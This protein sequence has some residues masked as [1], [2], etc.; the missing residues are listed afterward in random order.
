MTITGFEMKL[1]FLLLMN[2]TVTLFAAQDPIE[3]WME[4]YA[5][6]GNIINHRKSEIDPLVALTLYEKIVNEVPPVEIEPEVELLRAQLLYYGGKET[7]AFSI[8]DAGMQKYKT[9][10]PDWLALKLQAAI[11]NEEIN[12]YLQYTIEL[13][14]ILPIS[15][16][17]RQMDTYLSAHPKNSIPPE[18]GIYCYESLRANKIVKI[19]EKCKQNYLYTDQINLLLIS[20]YAYSPWQR[21]PKSAWE[22]IAITERKLGHDKLAIIAFLRATQASPDK[23]AELQSM[24]KASYANVDDGSNDKIPYQVADEM[25]DEYNKGYCWPWAIDILKRADKVNTSK[26]K[27]TVAAFKESCRHIL[28]FYPE[29]HRWG[30]RISDIDDYEAFHLPTPAETFWNEEFLYQSK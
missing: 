4:L 9:L 30:Q 1:L 6:S 19:I 2:M 22:D 10:L 17:G 12:K 20:I 26:L 18:D 13:G 3:H 5:E 27:E 25:A 15:S 21:I 14:Y 11:E 23:L 7:E 24:M 8:I 29:E 28:K 16:S